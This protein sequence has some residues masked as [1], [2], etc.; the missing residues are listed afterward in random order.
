MGKII[1]FAKKNLIFMI[2]DSF[3]LEMNGNISH[4][5]FIKRKNKKIIK[6]NK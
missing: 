4:F 3:F 1:I 5:L 2:V 6:K